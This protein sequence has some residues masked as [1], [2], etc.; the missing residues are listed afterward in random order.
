VV[1]SSPIPHYDAFELSATGELM[2]FTGQ[3]SADFNVRV[4]LGNEEGFELRNIVG[5]KN[6][7]NTTFQDISQVD[8]VQVLPTEGNPEEWEIVST[9]T[10]DANG[11][12]GTETVLISFLGDG[13]TEE[14]PV[15]ATVT[16]TTPILI[17]GGANKF[18]G[19]SAVILTPDGGCNVG[20][21]IIRV[22][23]GGA[24]RM[25]IMAA[26][27]VSKAAFYSTPVGK[28]AFGQFLIG[29]TAKNQDIEMRLM[30]QVDGG[31]EIIGG[32]LPSYQGFV[33]FPIIAPFTLSEKTDVRFQ[34][35]STNTAVTVTAFLD[36]LIVDNSKIAS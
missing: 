5:E 3:T 9:S 22:S 1:Q 29:L 6:N 20:D 15:I 33:A 26:E 10:D 28:T 13:W 35:K 16:G 11:G 2:D 25:K 31:P 30:S 34:V 27:G 17:P 19:V 14:T 23:S 8:G 12:S 21:L 7:V 32:V 18:R 36:L 4:F 24:E